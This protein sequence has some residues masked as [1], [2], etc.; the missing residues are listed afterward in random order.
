MSALCSFHGWRLRL[1]VAIPWVQVGAYQRQE[2]RHTERLG[3]CTPRHTLESLGNLL[4]GVLSVVCLC[5]LASAQHRES[6]QGGGSP[7]YRHQ[8]AA[9]SCAR[10]SPLRSAAPLG[11]H[12]GWAGVGITAHEANRERKWS[13]EQ[14][15]QEENESDIVT[16]T[17][18]RFSCSLNNRLKNF[19]FSYSVC[20]TLTLALI[21]WFMHSHI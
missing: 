5:T 21:N 10:Q 6:E 12:A 11:E 18:C 7:K 4:T 1:L 13:L 16:V 14:R 15:H 3:Q 17:N 8:R 19:I 20:S 9:W 2:L